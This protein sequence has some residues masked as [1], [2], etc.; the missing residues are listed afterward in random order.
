MTG[1]SLS[2]F[3]PEVGLDLLNRGVLGEDEE[4]TVVLVL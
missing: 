1:R 4:G 2:H 3:L